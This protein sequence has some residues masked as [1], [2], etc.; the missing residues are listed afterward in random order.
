VVVLGVAAVLGGLGFAASSAFANPTLVVDNVEDRVDATINGVCAASLPAANRCTL[1]AAIQEANAR[2]G[3]DVIKVLPGVYSI[4]I[5]PINENAS[6]VG[7]FEILDSLTIERAEGYLGEVIIDAGNPLPGSP[8]EQRGLDRIFEIHPGA[9]D[10]TLRNLTLRNGYHPE[11]GGAI[12]NWSLGKLTLDGVTV[13]DSYASEQGGGLNHGDLHDYPWTTEPPNLALLPHGRIEITRSTFTGNGSGGGGAAVNNTSGGTITISDDSVITLN[14]GPIMPDPLDPEEFVLIDPADYP[15]GASAIANQ[16]RWEGVGTIRILDSTVSANAAESNGGGISNEGDSVVAIERSTITGNR[17]AASGGGVYTEGGTVRVEDST[18]SMNRAA[19]GG[20]LYSGGHLSQ[21]GLRGRFE[22]EDSEISENVAENGGGLYSDGDAQLTVIDS[23]FAANLSSD[24]GAG[25]V[26]AGRASMTLTR[27][28]VADNTSNGEGGGVWTA[29]ERLQLITDSFFR[30]NRAG[31]PII[32]DGVLS[33][34]VAGGGGLHSS[35]GPLEVSGSTFEGNTATDEGGGLSLDNHGDVEIADSVITNNRALDGAGVENS[36]TRVTFERLTISRNRAQVHGGGIYNTSSGEFQLLNSTIRE[37]SAIVGGGLANAPDNHLIVRGSLFLNN[38]AR[39]GFTEE[40]EIDE[41][42]GKGGGLMSFADGQSLIENT[43]FSGNRAATGGGGLFHDADGEL[44]L[45]HVTIWRNSAPAGGAIGVVESDFVPDIP[46]KTNASVV[47]KNSI[48]GGSVEGGSC[49]WYVRSEGGNVDT[50]TTC[51]LAV[52][53]ETAQNPIELGVRDRRGDPE[54]W[55]IADNGGPTMTHAPQYGSLAIDSS[56]VP[57]AIVD[58]RGTARPQNGLCDAGAFEFVGEMPPEDGIAPDTFFVDGP[59]QD[60]LE[61]MAFRFGGVDSAENPDN[62]TPADRLS[63]ECRFI[64]HEL[65]EPPEPTAPWEPVEPELMWNGCSSPWSV[66]LIEEGLFTFE[67]RATDLAHNTDQTPHIQH[68]SGLNLNPPDTI[69]AEGPGLPGWQPGDPIFSTNSRAALFTFSGVDDLTPPQFLEF[70]C[71]LDTN[72]PELWLECLNP[73]MFSDLPSGLHTIHVRAVDGQENIDPTPARYTWR[74]G[75]DPNDPGSV[76]LDCDQANITLT[77]TADGWADQVN[78]L[79]NYRFETELTVRS[80]SAPAPNGVPGDVIG[81]NARAFFRFDVPNDNPSCTLES[82]TLRLHAD[83]STEGRTLQAV[84]LE[85]S[86]LQSTLTWVNQPDPFP[87]VTPATTESGEGYREWDVRAHVE[88]IMA[89][90]LPENGWVIRDAAETDVEGSGPEQSFTSREQPQDPPDV[91]LPELE[92]RFVAAGTPAPPAPP[93][94]GAPVE[95]H[96]GQVI[97]V[98]TRLAND[99]TGCLGEGIVIGAPNIVLDLNGKTVSSGLVLEPGEEDVLTPGIRSGRTNVVIRNGVV[100]GFGHGV[101]LG[102]GATHNVVHDMSLVRNALSGVH[103]FDADNGRTGNTVRDNLFDANGESG[104]SLFGGAEGSTV[105]NNTFTQ[106]GT[107]ILLN[108]ASRNTIR[109]NSISGIILD[110]LLDSDAGIV[111]ENS[112]RHNTLVDNDVSD[113]GDAGV[114]IHQGSHDNRV[115]G[116]VLVRN[117]DAGVIVEDSDRAYVTGVLAHG[118][119]DGGIGLSNSSGSFVIGN[120]VRHNPSGVDASNTNGLRVEGN[121][122]SD[123]LQSGIELGNGIGM[124][125]RNNTANRSG[126]SGISLEGAAFDAL[127]AAVGGALVEGNTTNENAENGLTVA[128]GGHTIRGNDAHNNAGFGILAGEEQTPGEPPTGTN[129]DGGG[130]RATGNLETVQCLGVL[131]EATGSLP[132]T[133]PDTT[134][135]D[136]QI[137]RA[138]SALTSSEIAVF[139]F[140]GNDGSTGTPVTALTFECRLDAPPDPA[141]PVDPPDLEPPDPNE[142]PDVPEPPEGENWAECVSPKTYMGLEPGPHHFEVRAVDQVDN[143][144]LTQAVHEWEIH[145]GA[146]DS[147]T[148]EDPPVPPETRLTATPGELTELRGADGTPL[149]D[150]HGQPVVFFGTT[151]R[152]ANLG[153]VGSDN[154]TAGYNLVFECRH[155][156]DAHNPRLDPAEDMP[157]EAVLPFEPCDSPWLLPTDLSPGSPGV[158]PTDS[159]R[160]LY[161]GHLVEVRAVDRAGNKDVSPAWHAWWIQPPPP[162]TVPPETAI[163]A[164]P[165]LTTVATSATFEFSGTDNQTPADVLTYQCALDG[166]P[167]VDCSSPHPVS[168]LAPHP[169]HVLQV[170]AVD[171]TGN[172]DPTPAAYVWA[173]GAAPVPRTVVCGQT[174]TQSIIVNNN[175]G[176][177]LGNGLIVG[178]DGI[179]IDLNGRTID[180]KSIGAGILNNGFDSVTV[181]N[182]VLAD[183]DFGVMLNTGAQHNIVEGVTA[184]QNQEAAVSLGQPTYPND[185]NAPTVPEDPPPGVQSQVTG[186]IIRSNTLVANARGVWLNNDANNNVV[187]GNLIGATAD[188]AVW[189]E[190]ARSNRIEGNDIQVASGAGVLL[191]GSTDNLVLDNSIVDT[192]TGVLISATTTAPTGIES[193]GNRVEGNLISETSGPA[194]E[195]HDSRQ[196]LLVDNVGTLTNGYA[197]ELYLADENVV[198]GNDVSGNKGGVSL[199]TSSGNRIEGNDASNS[200]STGITVESQSFSNLVIGNVSN[201]NDGGGIYIGDETPAGQG[202]LVQANTTNGNVGM[203]IQ[204]SKPAHIFVGN[205]AFDNDSWGIFVGD[206]SNGRANIDGGGNVAQGNQGPLGIDLKPQ[207]C[208]NITC[209]GGPGGG[210]QIAPNTTILEAPFDPSTDDV[211]MYRFTGADNA[212]P[213][214]FECRIDSTAETDWAICPSPKTY[215]LGL[216]AHTFEVRAVDVSGNADPT[217]ATHGWT[218]VPGT[219]VATIDSAPDRVTVSTDATFTFSANKSAGVTF[220]CALNL[221]GGPVVWEPNCSSPRTYTGL[222]VGDHEFRVRASAPGSNDDVELHTWTIGPP[223]IPAQVTCGQILTQSTRLLNDLINCGGHGLIVGAPGITIDLDGHFVDGMGL[224]AGIL[225]NGHD[226]VTITNGFVHE[227]LY[228]V[229]LN[230]GTARNVVHG[231]RIELAEEAGIALADADQDGEGNTIRDNTIVGNELGIALYSG[232][233]H[234][235]VRENTLAANA[236][237]GS[238]YLEFASDNLIERNQIATAGGTGVMMLG[239]GSNTVTENTIRQSSGFGIIAGE[240]L[241]QSNDNVILRNSI[242]G[243]QGGVL[244]GGHRNQIVNNDVVGTTGPG[245]VLEL[246]DDNVVRGNELG[247]SGSGI[248]V[249]ESNNNLIEANN[250][251]GTLGAGIEVGELSSNNI[252]RNNT[253]SSNGG[254]GIEISESSVIGQGNVIDGNTAD[255]NGGDGIYVEGVGHSISDNVAQLNGGWGIYSVGGTDAGGNLAAGNMEPDQCF[256]V[257]CILGSVPGAPDTWIVEGPADINPGTPG[258]QSHSRNASFTYMGVDEFTPITE[259]VFECRIDSTNPLAW[260]DC[261]YPAEFLNLSPG[262]HTFDVRAIDMM[263]QGLADP[264]PA[265]FTWTYV[266]L[267]SGVAPPPPILDVV[268]PAETWLPE[269]IFTFHSTEPDVSFQCRVDLGTWDPCGFEGAAFMS[270]GAY[271]A[272]LIETDVGPHTFY[273]RAIDFEGNVGEPATFTW[274]L[275]GVTV[276]FTDGPGFVPASGGPAGDPATGGPTM[277][278]SAEIHFEANMTDVVFMCRLDGLLGDLFEEC[279]SPFTVSGLLMGDHV[280]EVFAEPTNGIGAPEL[281]PSVYEWE[282]VEI[283]DTTPPETFLER[284]PGPA[285]LSSTVF[286]FV[287]TDDLTPPFLL[288][289]ECQVTNGTAPPNENEW[290]ACLSPFNLLDVYTYAEPPL[291]VSGPLTFYVRAV[292]LADPE[293]PNPQQPD[294]EGNPDPTPASHTWTPVPDTLAPSVAITA[295]LAEGAVVGEIEVPFEFVGSDNATPALGL[296]FQC[297]VESAPVDFGAALNWLPCSTPFDPSVEPGTYTFAVRGV[298]LAGNAGPPATRSFTVAAPPVVTILSGPPGRVDPNTGA[299]SLPLASTESAVFTFTSDQPGSTFACSVDGSDF[300]LCGGLSEPWTHAA[301]VVETGTHEFAVRATNPQFIVGEETVYEW[302]VELGPDATEPNSTIT[303]GPETGTLVQEATLTFTGTDNRTLGMDLAFECA[304]DSTTSWNSCTSPEQLSDLTRGTHTFYV[305]AID[306]A[307]NVESTPASYTWFVAAPPLATILSGPGVEQEESTSRSATF[308]FVSNVPGATFECWLDGQFNPPQ[309]TGCVS[310]QTYE[311]L[312]LGQHLFAVRAVDAFGNLG[313]WE[314][315]E[316][317]VLPPQAVLTG[318]PASG[319]STTATFEFTSE[320]TDPAATFYCS[321]DGRPFG[322]CTSPKSYSNLWAGEHTFQVQ[323]VFTGLDW[324]GQPLELDPIPVTH[325]WTVVDLTAP[326]TTID[327]GPAATTASVNAYLGVSSDDPTATIACTLDGASTECEPGVVVELT[328]LAAG[329]HTFT[330]QATD[331][332]GNVDASPAVYEWTIAAPT[333]PPN[334]PVGTNVSVTVG[335]ITVTFFSV[336]TAGTTIADR[337]GGG[338]SLPDGFGGGST[339]IYDISTTAAFGEPVTVCFDYDPA[340][341]GGPTPAVRLLHFDGSEWVDITTLNNPFVAPARLCGLAESFS[342]FAVALASPGMAPETSIISG[343]TGPLNDEGFPTS[344]STMATFEFWADQP[345][346][347]TLCSI[348]GEPFV[349]CESPFTVGPLEPG[350]QEFQVQAVNAFGWMDLTPAIYEWEIVLGP[351]TT[352]PDTTIVNGPPEGSSTPNYISVFE[353]AGTDNQTIPLELDFVCTLDGVD[354]GNCEALEEIEVTTAGPH[355]LEVAAVDEAGNVDETPAVRNW[356]VVDMSPPDTEVLTGP[357]E[358]TTETSATFTF[359][360]FEEISGEPVNQFECSLDGTDFVACTSPHTIAGPIGGGPHVFQVRAVDPAGNRDISPAFWE[361]LIIGPP[362]TTP[363]DTFIVVHPPVDNSG[364]DVIFGFASDEHVEG[365]ECALDQPSVETATWEPCE[366]VWILEG[367]ASGPHTLWVRAIDIAGNVD[368]TPAPGLAPFT[369]MTTGEPD[370]FIDSGP[371]DPTGAFTAIFTFHSDQAGAT[372]QCSVNGSP[373]VSCSS[374]YQAGPFLPG[375]EGAP[376]EHEFEVRAVNQFTNVDGEQVVDLSPAVYEWTVQDTGAPDTV[377]LGAVE[378]GPEQLLDPGLRFSFRGTDDF[379]SVFELE[380]ECLIDNTADADAPVWEGCGEPGADD[381]FF[382]DIVFEDLAAGPYTFEVRALDVT[383]NPDPTPA[384]VPPYQFLA[385]AEPETTIGLVTP[386]M[387]V[388][389]QTEATSVTFEF[390]GTGASF[391]CALDSTVFTPCTS[392]AV[393]DSVPYGAHLFRVQAVS[394]LGTRDATPAE[395]E[396]ESGFLTAPDVTLLSAPPTGTDATTAT[397]EF[398]STDPAASF[399]CTLDGLTAPC[400]SPA[401]YTGLRA[402]VEH[403]FEVVATKA[404]LLVEGVPAEWVWTII[405]TVAP[406]TQLQPP[407]PASPSGTEVELLFTGTDNGTLP[408]DLDFECALDGGPFA[409]CSSPHQLSSLPGGPH[410]FEVRALDQAGLADASP[411]TF[412]WDVVAPPATVIT[413]APAELSTSPDATFTFVDQPG[414]TYECRLDG[415][416]VPLPTPFADC[417]SGMV[418]YTNLTNGV[419]RFEVRATTPLGVLEDPPV[420]YEWT[421]DA[422]DIIAP[423]TVVTLGPATST[424]S[425]SATF[426]LSGTD[427]LTAPAGL[428]FECSL[429]GAA[430]ADCQNGIE[431]V[432]LPPGGHTFAVRAVDEAGNIDGTPVTYNWTVVDAGGPNTPL[433]TDVTVAV[434]SGSVTFAN[435]SMAGVTS[436]SALSGTAELPVGYSTAGVLYFDV[437][438]TAAFTGDVTVCL[439]YAGSGLSEPRLLHFAGAWTDVA[440]EL[441][442]GGISCGVVGSLSPFALADAS[443]DLVPDTTFAEVPDDPT[444]QSTEAGAEV[445]HQFVATLPLSDFEC[446]LDGAGWSSCDSPLDTVASIGSHTLSVRAVSEAGLHDLTPAVDTWTVVARPVATIHSGPADEAPEDPDIQNEST[447]ATFEFSSDQ[448][449]STFECQL[450]AE[451]AGTSWE[452]CTSPKQYTG[453]GLDEYEFEVRAINA[454]GHAS[455]LPARY[456]WEV[457]DLTPPDTTILSGPSDPTSATSATLTFAADEDATFECWL[458]GA[459]LVTCPSPITFSG[460]DP[461]EHEF[462]VLA[463]DTSE[464]ENIELEPAVHTWTV[465]TTDPETAIDGVDSGSVVIHFSGSDNHSPQSA[466][467]FECRLDGAGYAPCVSPVSYDNPSV[468]DHTF[469]A[470]AVDEAG[471]VDGTPAAHSWTTLDTTAPETTI[472]GHPVAVTT[473]TNASFTF[474]GSDDATAVS[475]L[476]FQCALDTGSF[477]ACSSPQAYENLAP[478]LHTFQVRALDAAANVDGTPAAYSWTIEVPVDTTAPETTITAQ[479]PATTT[480]TTASFSFTGTDDVSAAGALTFECALNAGAFAPCTSPRTYSSLTPGAYTF[481][482]RATDAAGNV[483]QS[484]ASFSWTIQA[485]NCGSQQTLTASADSWLDQGSPTSNKGSDSTLK[486]MSKGPNG[487]LRVVVRFNLPTLPPGCSV[488]SA[489]LRMHANSATAGRTLEA[490]R[491]AATWSEGGITWANQPATTGGAVTTTSGTG[492]REWSVAGQ[493]QAMYSGGNHGFLVRD[494]VENQDAEQQFNSRSSSTN[495]P[496]LVIRFGSGPPPPPP[497]GGPDTT[498]PDTTLTGTPLAATT[499][500]AATFTFTG[501]DDVTAATSL[502]FQCQLDVPVTSPWTACTSPANFSPLATGSHTFRVRAVDAAGNV[503]QSPAVYTWTIDQTAPET[504]ISS[505][506]QATTTSTSAT[507]HFLSPETGS[508]FACSLDTAPFAACTSPVTHTGLAVG[509]HTFRVQATDA[510]GNIDQTPATHPWTIQSGGSVDCGSPVT[511]TAVADAWVDQ[512]SPSSNK[513][514][515]SILKVLSKSGNGNLRALV[516]FDLPVAPAGCVLDT[517]TLRVFAGSA[518]ATERTLEVLRLGGSWSESG[519]TW[520]NQPATAGSAV[521]TSSG[522]GYRQWNVAALVQAMYSSGTSHGFLIRDANEGQDAEQQFYSREKGESPPQLVVTFRPA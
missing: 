506:P 168:G 250:A 358:E 50:D 402:G 155:H 482:V 240:E 452:P 65:T 274:T 373:Y 221:A 38:A 396:W 220:E 462:R 297:I 137:T 436:I 40:G 403:T 363:P 359:E 72:D 510:A 4:T 29:S 375:E 149:V 334:T 98:S 181:R 399:L 43:T 385:D 301:W 303:S 146:D 252:V 254:D 70:E 222:A 332:S 472:T 494:A 425:T 409:P 371:T 212:S 315:V 481:R 104:V 55:A 228:G 27:V 162:D 68:I 259:I 59:I 261:E 41:N 191:E 366:P 448:L 389:L 182:G 391:E 85:D 471:N 99:V 467:A 101:L 360:G 196:N 242:N 348:D 353:F 230:P 225:N 465:D 46:P 143:F 236:G 118:Q 349:F 451:T 75:P 19:N 144:D 195:I 423:D 51:F 214:H 424:T 150:E 108:D 295:G 56:A 158:D 414:S 141:E 121:D 369:W 400:A 188:D 383:G 456:E 500:S 198:V 130:N 110:P 370:T 352:P 13:Q 275:L 161:G 318:V 237:E 361:W 48:V 408:A 401:L 167:F 164:G 342:L 277:S 355:T 490:F 311:N 478:G 395:F 128:D 461:G 8:P 331:P 431:L 183:F 337:L 258:V 516:R 25:I 496:Q 281:E 435:V 90:A 340:D 74:V 285:D 276:V 160:L 518:S 248:V 100:R 194:L 290:V 165:D 288:G 519:V 438:T 374:P 203:G 474:T 502:G 10:V 42:A 206:P 78:P 492:Y 9:G 381:T 227:F 335:D 344:T 312:G 415:V 305:R 354:L 218:I 365:Y 521:T 87:G 95:V 211:A 313:L 426:L 176:D 314:D 273:V 202:T 473:N 133:P 92:L 88:A 296:E 14:P 455:L 309:G 239:G 507:F 170:R 116:G 397:F 189:I 393:S 384:P 338:P 419:H 439:P 266:P 443:A 433:G 488:E 184:Q 215:N 464:R 320:P 153:F 317:V 299:V 522:T 484:P 125:V 432:D 11:E 106:N 200:E 450:L 63:F 154:L 52:T 265:S 102:P 307:G 213:V 179:T 169:Q 444:V 256:G 457:A 190:R 486:V 235:V 80:D 418:S 278:T 514:S 329:P 268:P 136:T 124:V 376:E 430:F 107:S 316:F 336:D 28:E 244:V 388:D 32:E 81:A 151:N 117:G 187:H 251:S 171:A 127:G 180:G 257:V 483:D 447:T 53:A 47:V 207:Q 282:V 327:F 138:P 224:D 422:P 427:N 283:L 114:R 23:S 201:N 199:K 7:D 37:N 83:G 497:P 44:R 122:A 64:E 324:M 498:A 148:L 428:T 120:D 364:P 249:T 411:A 398:N 145:L 192:S 3:A 499:Q 479:P 109:N 379:T 480:L 504:I 298:D 351:D 21:H 58:Q 67:V 362:D 517:A 489:T 286:E 453:L 407:L 387:G 231:M 96:C 5:A 147:D 232:T 205:I 310:G 264:T 279:T 333:G 61:T 69:I 357:E 347:I 470:R 209:T 487:N 284:A 238:I 511:L 382:H 39:I 380:F 459:V 115:E 2:P 119:S 156:Y 93:E 508:T 112:S 6:N 463:T 368:P 62:A 175:L 210:D 512:S 1:R 280:L 255:S 291:S 197:I 193:T 441:R 505:G 17:T 434:G 34:D 132:V 86:W 152:T 302:Q 20:G 477:V 513:G 243:G 269:A 476:S 84:P 485:V 377:F 135:P 172:A 300:V 412:T 24:H 325:T 142:P 226:D 421:V 491:L 346:A 105:E 260:E 475:G 417:S 454:A 129:I 440:F 330:A 126:G 293:F 123:S 420:E 247:G 503:D 134:A 267:P 185:P 446:S 386:D 173:V 174:I 97:T 323:T 394:A 339:A 437:S 49:D 33:D 350:E 449:P 246:A 372:F 82:A 271:E 406:E 262:E 501:V 66:P 217:P 16:S 57:C 356:I 308:T 157:S 292:D 18:V 45:V 345:D 166:G 73:T 76:P 404:N 341:Y 36:A 12:Q 328:D 131:C 15:L 229:Q 219:L 413:S 343:P 30:G 493:V 405:D 263:G 378:I 234:A 469:E 367:L 306:G 77:A 89:G 289:F 178:A 94:P 515:D 233:R 390:S 60:S 294:F 35:S 177:C 204:A 26:S 270:Q 159:T 410:V 442:P 460:L 458:D 520:D 22:V 186:N 416:D 319:T 139:E 140:T 111:L 509:P 113:T 326:D 103:L 163:I 71:R 392:P 31:V 91:T 495:R 245:V 54:L 208:Y 304:L 223:P 468:G 216:G 429:D 79:E 241:L 272:Q 287:G 466:L 321:L 445:R 253:T 322:L